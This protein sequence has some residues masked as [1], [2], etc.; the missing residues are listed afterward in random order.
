MKNYRKYTIV[1]HPLERLLSAYID[2]LSGPILKV[3]VPYNYFEH[4]KHEIIK[5]YNTIDYQQ[6]N[7]SNQKTLIEVSFPQ[8]VHWISD[9][10]LDSINEH[11]MPQYHNC[12]PCRM[13]YHFYGSFNNFQFDST[14]ILR[15]FA[16][17]F[18]SYPQENYA[19]QGKSTSQKMFFYY[20]R[21]P[22]YLKHLLYQKFILEFDFYHYLYPLEQSLTQQLLEL[23][24]Y[25]L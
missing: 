18:P 23:P 9:K 16:K 24:I 11:F 25:N 13:N 20:S 4:L 21:L 8:F 17:D 1:R 15:Q 7:H 3:I 10:D 22:T 5:M 6:L 2:K 12:Q 14:Q 19:R